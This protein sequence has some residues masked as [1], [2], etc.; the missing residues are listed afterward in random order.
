MTKQTAERLAQRIANQII[1]KILD[2][3]FES[4][5]INKFGGAGIPS[6]ILDILV[7]ILTDSQAIV[8]GLKPADNFGQVGTQPVERFGQQAVGEGS[9]LTNIEADLRAMCVKRE[10]DRY[11]ACDRFR[12]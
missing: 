2:K 6:E 9:V 1:N 3:K 11:S 5:H 12:R 4:A 8:A 10:D 7:E